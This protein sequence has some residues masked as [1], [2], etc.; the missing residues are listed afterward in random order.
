MK[1][2]VYTGISNVVLNYTKS[3]PK[4]FFGTD[5]NCLNTL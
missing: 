2:K 3:V 4:F 5:L 1:L